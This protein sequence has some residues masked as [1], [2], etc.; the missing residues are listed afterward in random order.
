MH[1]FIHGMTEHVRMY[2]GSG[3]VAHTASQWR[4][5]HSAG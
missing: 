1:K 3:T 2:Y 4:H 5:T